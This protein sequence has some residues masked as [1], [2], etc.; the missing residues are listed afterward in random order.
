MN[1]KTYELLM[2]RLTEIMDSSELAKFVTSPDFDA[3][4]QACAAGKI[5]I[6]KRSAHGFELSIDDRDTQSA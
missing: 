4:K 6:L 5:W 1:E 3:V 2:Q